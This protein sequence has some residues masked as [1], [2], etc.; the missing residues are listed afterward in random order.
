M[1][2]CS[3]FKSNHGFLLIEHLL[4]LSIT[5]ILML[6]LTQLI[7]MIDNYQSNLD[8]VTPQEMSTLTTQL[9]KEA[10]RATHFS[11]R[12]PTF[13]IH[14]KDGSIATYFISNH[15]LMRQING[16]GG[17]V[18]LYDCD[19]LTATIHH[20]QSATLTLTS[21]VGDVY[22]IYLSSILLPFELEE[23]NEE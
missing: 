3:V 16:K 4:A 2:G 7:P 9:Q 11:Y 23:L 17:E 20:D 12:S 18:A 21:S 8:K 13:S 10:Q 19:K 14:L 1:R 15:R 22:S 5:S 6:T